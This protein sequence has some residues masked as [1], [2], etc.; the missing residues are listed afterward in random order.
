MPAGAPTQGRGACSRGHPYAAIL[1]VEMTGSP[2]FPHRPSCR[3]AHAPWTPEEP[4]GTCLV[5]PPD[6]ATGGETAV[7][8]SM[9][10]FRGSIAWPDD[11]LSTLQS[12][13]LPRGNAR[14]ASQRA[15]TLSGVGFA[16][17]GSVLKSFRS[18]FSSHRFLLSRAYLAQSRFPGQGAEALPTRCK[19]RFRLRGYALSGGVLTHRACYEKFQL[20][21][22]FTSHSLSRALLGAIPVSPLS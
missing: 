2:K 1:P 4:A 6:A 8:S 17:T 10:N 13:G 21:V 9:M 18:V 20:C 14:L 3:P 22:Q 11:L 19:T 16:P 12:D 5:A 7:A 15:A